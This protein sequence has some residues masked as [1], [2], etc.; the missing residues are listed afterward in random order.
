MSLSRSILQ[1][2][3]SSRIDNR[4]RGIKYAFGLSVLNALIYWRFGAFNAYVWNIAA[5]LAILGIT[6][7]FILHDLDSALKYLIRLTRIILTVILIAIIHFIVF[8][9]IKLGGLLT[10]KRFAFPQIRKNTESY[11][12]AR[13]NEW[14][15]N[16]HEPF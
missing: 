16:I 2:K 9:L 8:P 14:K 15:K 11:Y 4:L 13:N 3:I 6:A 7:P 5:L 12:S 10:G 1:L